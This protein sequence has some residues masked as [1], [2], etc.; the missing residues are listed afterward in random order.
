M[1]FYSKDKYTIED[2]KQ[3]IDNEVEE[4]KIE[5]LLDELEK[6]YNDIDTL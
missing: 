3:L 4:N 2:I 6:E 1:D 5:A